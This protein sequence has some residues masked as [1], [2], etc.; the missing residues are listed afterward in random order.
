MSRLA[1]LALGQAPPARRTDH[2]Y[3]DAMSQDEVVTPHAF[4][5]SEG[6]EIWIVEI[7]YSLAANTDNM[8]VW[9]NHRV[10]S[11]RFMQRRQ[12]CNNA[13]PLKRFQGR[14]D[15]SMGDGW[16][17]PFD[18]A[19]EFVGTG[20]GFIPEKSLVDEQPLRGDLQSSSSALIDKLLNSRFFAFPDHQWPFLG[21]ASIKI[22]I[23]E[24]KGN[25]A[26]Q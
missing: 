2:I 22:A 10:E 3:I 16:M 21:R 12:P 25:H 8:M 13:V 6:I 15:C 23:G 17:G 14:V 20:M 9:L 19:I 1:R 4:G 24:E 11:H 5:D 18:S 26:S 7:C